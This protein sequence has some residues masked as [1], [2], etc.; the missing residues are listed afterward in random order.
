MHRHRHVFLCACPHSGTRWH[1]CPSCVGPCPMAE[2]FG[3]S[4]AVF[5]ST[6]PCGGGRTARARRPLRLGD[7]VHI[8][9]VLAVAP[10][11]EQVSLLCAGCFRIAAEPLPV[12]CACR[13]AYF[14]SGDCRAMAAASDHFGASHDSIC[15][16][17]CRWGQGAGV[18]CQTLTHLRLLLHVYAQA[19]G[20][21][22]PT[23][24]GRLA[25]S[26]QN[27]LG[28]LRQL[29]WHPDPGGSETS[30][31][32]R[33]WSAR[34]SRLGVFD[35]GRTLSSGGVMLGA[36][37]TSAGAGLKRLGFG[38]TSVPMAPCGAKS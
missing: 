19:L 8:A 14:C 20:R 12:R 2:L 7:A 16:V 38:R 24:V 33:P 30:P 17:L 31:G 5:L 36:A 4:S 15:H 11:E 25:P 18:P 1:I 32:G 22:L 29:H 9:P 37:Q 26:F 10:F 34:W 13:I 28:A 3:D 23:L 35:I 6:T 27:P 21:S